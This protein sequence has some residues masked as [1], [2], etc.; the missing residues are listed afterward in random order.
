MI[1]ARTDNPGAAAHPSRPYFSALDLGLTL[2]YF[3]PVPWLPMPVQ[4]PV[5]LALIATALA[6]GA[7]IVRRWL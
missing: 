4:Y 5:V 2:D 1:A 3:K 6:F 7:T